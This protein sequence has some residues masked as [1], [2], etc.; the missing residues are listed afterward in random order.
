MVYFILRGRG[1]Q[2]ERGPKREHAR[3]LSFKAR[4]IITSYQM[5]NAYQGV[6]F[7]K[8]KKFTFSFD[9][10]MKWP[11]SVVN[12][13]L[14]GPSCSTRLHHSFL[15]A[16]LF[17]WRICSGCT[18]CCLK[19]PQFAPRQVC[20]QAVVQY[21]SRDAMRSYSWHLASTFTDLKV[22]RRVTQAFVPCIMTLQ[23][24]LY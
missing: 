19:M 6:H 12:V 8:F 20:S 4:M 5:W 7:K 2:G 15:V 11:V 24:T 3:N 21:I 1:Q 10:I 14:V 16:C 18:V 22:W 17:Q 13:C 9:Y 23:F